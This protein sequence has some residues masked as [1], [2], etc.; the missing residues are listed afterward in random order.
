VPNIFVATSVW[1][2]RRGVVEDS[3]LPGYDAI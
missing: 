1:G 2:T 3:G